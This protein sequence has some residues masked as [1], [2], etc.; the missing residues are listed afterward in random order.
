M[1]VED[2]GTQPSLICIYGKIHCS[3]PRSP[4]LNGQGLCGGQRSMGANK[5]RHSS[6]D[7]HTKRSSL[8]KHTYCACWHTCIVLTYSDLPPTSYASFY[9]YSQTMLNQEIN[10]TEPQT[11]ISDRKRLSLGHWQ[12]LITTNIFSNVITF[13]LMIEQLLGQRNICTS[14]TSLIINCK[15]HRTTGKWL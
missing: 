11:E 4:S 13:T 2:L 10:W 6:V 1:C 9:N 7:L 12:S 14:L 5:S 3:C 8:T 15:N